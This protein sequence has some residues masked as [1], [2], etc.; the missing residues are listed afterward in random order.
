MWDK[1]VTTLKLHYLHSGVGGY[2]VQVRLV[3]VYIPQPERS[4][5]MHTKTNSQVRDFLLTHLPL[6]IVASVKRVKKLIN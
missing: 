6:G 1:I 3:L 5:G 4:I 2:Y